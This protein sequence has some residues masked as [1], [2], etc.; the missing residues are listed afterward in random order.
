MT[1]KLNDIGLN[2]IIN[3]QD[4]MFDPHFSDTVLPQ[5]FVILAA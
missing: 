3:D 2:R 1:Q 4:W 5:L